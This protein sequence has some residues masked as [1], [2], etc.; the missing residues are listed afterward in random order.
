MQSIGQEPSPNVGGSTRHPFDVPLQA[1]YKSRMK[2]LGVLLRL[3]SLHQAK[4]VRPKGFPKFVGEPGAQ[5]QGP[6]VPLPAAV[7]PVVTS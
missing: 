1:V 2:Q 6:R 3:R 5:P 7:K 4:V